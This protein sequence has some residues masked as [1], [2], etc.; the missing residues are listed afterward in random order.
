MPGEGTPESDFWPLQACTHI[1]RHLSLDSTQKPFES[2]FLTKMS[3]GKVPAFLQ[4][5]KRGQEQS[6]GEELGDYG[7]ISKKRLRCEGPCG[8]FSKAGL[9]G[10]HIRSRQ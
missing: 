2:N 4:E 7:R 3:V 10:P 6:L 5:R 8:R 1:H 9:L